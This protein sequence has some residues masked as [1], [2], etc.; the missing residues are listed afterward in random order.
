M[1]AGLTLLGVSLLLFGVAFLLGRVAALV[2]GW[3]LMGLP[4]LLLGV[5]ALLG[6]V[7]ASLDEWTVVG[8]PFML[9]GIAALL[10]GVALLYRPE[11]PRRLVA[12]LTHEA[13]CRSR[14]TVTTGISSLHVTQKAPRLGIT[15]KSRM[16]TPAAGPARLY[17]GSEDPDLDG[18]IGTSACA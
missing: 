18:C 5:A 12:W 7:A 16:G 1:L 10:G 6:G 14:R 11:L 15:K 17:K 9:L 13:I 3:A 8:V 4:F 2:D